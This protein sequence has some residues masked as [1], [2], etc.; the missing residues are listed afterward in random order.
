MPKC[1][2]FEYVSTVDLQNVHITV[3]KTQNNQ[4]TIFHWLIV[5][6]GLKYYI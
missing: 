3:K 6:I 2:V 4:M 5:M 1:G